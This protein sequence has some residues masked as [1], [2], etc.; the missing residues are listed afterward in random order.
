[1]TEEVVVRPRTWGAEVES[2]ESV[3]LERL[4]CRL[5]AEGR[6]DELR[7]LRARRGLLAVE[8]DVVLLLL[9]LLLDAESE[10]PTMAGAAVAVAVEEDVCLAAV[11]VAVVEGRR[12]RLTMLVR[13]G[14]TGQGARGWSGWKAARG[15]GVQN[16]WNGR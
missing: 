11:M 7:L 9:L 8:E 3:D 6:C 5:S 14:T 1:V 13:P 4:T 16:W 2:A 10:E 15:G 12:F